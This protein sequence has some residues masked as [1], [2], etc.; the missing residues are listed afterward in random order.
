MTARLNWSDHRR[1][2]VVAAA[3]FGMMSAFGVSTTVAVVM[4]PF[5]TEFGWQRADIALA[6]TLLSAGTAVGGLVCGS[7]ADRVN[8][9]AMVVFGAA[10]MAIGLMLL[11]RQDDL[12]AIQNIYLAIGVFGFACLYAP[13]I[14]TVGLWFERGRGVAIGIVTAGGTLGQ[15]IAPLILQPLISSFGWRDAFLMLGIGYAVLL[16]P[17]MTLV[18][19]PNDNPAVAATS[20]IGQQSAKWSLPPIVSI[21]WLGVAAIF[22]CVTMAVPLVHLVTL[23]ADRGLSP[24]LA[25]SVLTTVMFAGVAGR[26]AFGT[27]ADV[28]GPF[29]SYAL[30]SASQTATVFWFVTLDS[31]PSLYLLAILFGLGF[32]GVMTTLLLCVREAVPARSAG[33]A[34]AVIGLLAWA[35]MGVGAYQGGYCY[36]ATGDY[37]MSF[38]NAAVGGI[39]NLMVVAGL[40]AHMRALRPSAR[41]W[42][43]KVQ[44]AVVKHRS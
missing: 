40:A 20:R 15:G 4:K 33:T 5:E 42:W 43:S 32:S 14:A 31:L 38:A 21:G 24:A 29:K 44:P 22:C 35:G 26:L 12:A 16:V 17:A 27:I 18:T 25:G 37:T 23:A 6:Y 9:R 36:D 7:F 28:I 34:T 11:S 41:R 3:T 13:L 39:A 1:W 2:V 19:K 30:A 10:V 8:T